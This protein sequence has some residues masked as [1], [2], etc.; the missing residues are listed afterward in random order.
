MRRLVDGPALAEFLQVPR[1]TVRAWAFRGKIHRVGFDDD[2]R[3]LY[4]V[5]EALRHAEKSGLRPACAT[6]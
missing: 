3:A 2:G 5:D 6:P 4:D 1:S